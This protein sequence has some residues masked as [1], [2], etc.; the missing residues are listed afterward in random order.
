MGYSEDE[1]IALPPSMYRINDYLLC[2]HVPCATCGRPQKRQL[3][4]G[5]L[6]VGGK[7]KHSNMVINPE[8]L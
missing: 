8:E 7:E 5:K 6:V 3:Q 1:I 4:R 2:G